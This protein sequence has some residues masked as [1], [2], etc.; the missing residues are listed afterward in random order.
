MSC[1][2]LGSVLGRTSALT[3][4]GGVLARPLPSFLSAA[5]PPL[6]RR[7][8]RL[9]SAVAP[10]AVAEEG[11]FADDDRSIYATEAEALS[12]IRSPFLQTMRD[13][14]FLHQCTGLA[15]LDALLAG[16]AEEGGAAAGPVA[17]Y[18]G[19]D[20]TADS[21]HVGSLLQIMILRH[22]QRSGH[23]PI[24]LIGGGTSKVGDPTGKDESRKLLTEETIQKNADGIS[25]VF[26][27][28]LQ[29]GDGPTDAAMVNNDDWLSELGYLQFLRD[30][31]TAFTINRM[32]SFESVKQRMAR[33]SPLSFLEFNYMIL[34]AYDFLELHR[35]LGVRLQLGGSDQWGNMVSGV[36]LGRKADR[37]KL[38]AVTAPLVT[39]AD[40]KKMGKTEGGAIWLNA[41]R[42]SEYDYWQFWRNTAD[43]DVG[44]FLRL[45]T[46]LPL[47][48]VAEL[49]KLTGAQINDAKIVLADEATRLLHGDACLTNIRETVKS[50]FTAK[51]K[52]EGDT[53]SLP[54]IFVTREEL[55]TE[56]GVRFADLFLKLEL[57]SSKK[58][59]R[60]LIQGGGAKME[61]EK[62]QD[63]NGA[64][65]L[66]CFGDKSEVTLRAG[67]KRA[68]VVELQK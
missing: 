18:L 41:D 68:G 57:A 6:R 2:F 39:T 8:S 34:Q 13:R 53:S 9:S 56:G 67:K 15:E 63:Q 16:E 22:Y 7:S 64:M 30:Y 50:M 54:R 32:M 33:D 28:F 66:E 5:S 12:K 62:I 26:Q 1:A 43:A 25:A 55:E 24:V 19:F 42:L 47:E 44:R 65:T 29:F 21:L 61:G 51:G 59:A 40:G 3:S 38:F 49:E 23:K 52:G 45:F 48:R 10:S 17:A 36:E 20:A 37:A 14:G 58:D 46:E 60:R 4:S 31:G 27:K 11:T 35:R